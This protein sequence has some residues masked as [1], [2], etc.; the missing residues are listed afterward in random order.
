MAIEGGVTGVPRVARDVRDAG[1]RR[2]QVPLHVHRERLERRHVEDAAPFAAGGAGSNISR[3]RH[4]KKR[5]QRFAAAGRRQDECG[6]A[7]RDGRPPQLLGPG[8]FRKGAG[9]PLARGRMKEI[10]RL[11]TT[12]ESELYVAT[13]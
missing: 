13:V 4:H 3:F 1:K 12:H 10:E 2:A 11:S 6:F 9:E 7:A 5:R 8:R